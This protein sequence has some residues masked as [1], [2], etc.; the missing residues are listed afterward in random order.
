MLPSPSWFSK[1]FLPKWCIHS[2][3]TGPSYVSM[4]PANNCFPGLS[5]NILGGAYCLQ[6]NE[7]TQLKLLSTST[8]LHGAVSQKAVILILAAVRTWN[9]TLGKQVS[10]PSP[11][12]T[13]SVLNR[14]S[15]ESLTCRHANVWG[16]S[17]TNA[18]ELKIWNFVWVY[19]KK[20]RNLYWGNILWNWTNNNMADAWP[21][22][23]HIVTWRL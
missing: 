11:W 12:D 21:V 3:P 16:Y 23:M 22:L 4:C 2:F 6:H 7:I 14:S 20:G 17:D 1:M 5:C 10:R 9:F 15:D 18:L 8:R 13:L 19:V